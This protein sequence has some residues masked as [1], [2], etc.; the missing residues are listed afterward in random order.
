[1]G[2]V[3]G[4]LDFVATAFPGEKALDAGGEGME[5]P[6]KP[7]KIEGVKAIFVPEV[8]GAGGFCSGF[9]PG[10]EFQPQVLPGIL[11]GKAV[12]FL[13]GEEAQGVEVK[14]KNLRRRVERAVG[15]EKTVE[16]G[17]K[18]VDTRHL[19]CGSVT[20]TVAGIDHNKGNIAR[21]IGDGTGM[22]VFIGRGTM[23]GGLAMVERK[24]PLLR[25]ERTLE[26]R[27][28]VKAEQIADAQG[29]LIQQIVR[30]GQGAA[31]G[32]RKGNKASRC[33][34]G[35]AGVFARGGGIHRHGV[36]YAVS[37]WIDKV[38]LVVKVALL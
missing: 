34:Q 20:D 21:G 27:N 16:G 11:T 35:A 8:F 13:K 10:K 38:I 17:E 32:E 19:G 24:H 15:K 36:S 28:A 2:R 25:G 3:V 14:R 33:A 29:E 1:M 18:R 4:E 6:C 37:E 9:G 30:T 31:E 22:P 23:A 12:A 7:V 26:R 5:R